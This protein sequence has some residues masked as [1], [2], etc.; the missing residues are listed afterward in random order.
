M[1][2]AMA[3]KPSKSLRE[4]LALGAVLPELDAQDRESAL[5]ALAHCLSDSEETPEAEVILRSLIEREQLGTTAI[6]HG[7]AIPHGKLSGMESAHLAL[8]RCRTG[9]DCQ[10]TDKEPVRLLIAIITP[11]DSAVLH[12]KILARISRLLGKAQVRDALLAA[13]TAETLRETLCS[14]EENL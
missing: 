14:A 7:V 2:T 1:E 12:L 6:G 5:R 10:S 9:I 11:S 13:T 3:S 8:G 4:M